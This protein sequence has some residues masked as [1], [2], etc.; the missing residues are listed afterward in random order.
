MNPNLHL[1]FSGSDLG[2][3]FFFNFK[4]DLNGVN[5][6]LNRLKINRYVRVCVCE[7]V[8]FIISAMRTKMAAFS[9]LE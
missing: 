8:F 2:R 4:A 1:D 6:G 9:S 3:V 7:R 5:S